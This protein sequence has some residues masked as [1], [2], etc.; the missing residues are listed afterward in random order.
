LMLKERNQQQ[1]KE[2]PESKRKRL[3]RYQVYMFVL[4]YII[5]IGVHIQRE[6]W[7]MSKRTIKKQNPALSMTYLGAIDTSLY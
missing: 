7:A 6:F 1:E 5:W 4:C 2:Q 3:W